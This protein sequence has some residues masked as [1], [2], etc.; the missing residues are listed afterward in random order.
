MYCL[1]GKILAK[2][3][4]YTALMQLVTCI[5]S[6]DSGG[7]GG[8]DNADGTTTTTTT[9]SI[10]SNMLDEMLILA[11]GTLIKSNVPGNKVESLIKL[12]KDRSMK[13]V[14]FMGVYILATLTSD[15]LFLTDMG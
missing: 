1:A 6:S 9:D 11:V 13:V 5:K 4:Q 10:V 3:E 12:I 15:I 14:L 7:G 2:H 8:S